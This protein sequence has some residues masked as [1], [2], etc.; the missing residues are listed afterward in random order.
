MQSFQ[1]PPAVASYWMDPQHI[2][3]NFLTH[4][5]QGIVLQPVADLQKKA[6]NILP[7]YKRS[8]KERERYL[9]LKIMQTQSY[10]HL[11]SNSYYCVQDIVCYISTCLNT[12]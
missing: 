2:C 4:T 10:F 12:F 6:E 8:R 11:I 7:L 1:L 5:H 3:N 9:N